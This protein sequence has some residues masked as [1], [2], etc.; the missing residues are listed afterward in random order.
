MAKGGSKQYP[1]LSGYLEMATKPVPINAGTAIQAILAVAGSGSLIAGT[2]V[3]LAGLGHMSWGVLIAECAPLFAVPLGCALG[4]VSVQKLVPKRPKPSALELEAREVNVLLKKH[5][6]ERRLHKAAPEAVTALLEELS[7]QYLRVQTTLS[8]NFWRTTDLP[9]PYVA[10]RDKAKVASDRAM[11]EAVVLL[12]PRMSEVVKP[13][14]WREVVDEVA[15]NLGFKVPDRG[16][17]FPA[18]I[19]PVRNL[20]EG[21][22]NLANEVEQAS[23]RAITELPNSSSAEASL[24]SCLTEL[25]A[26]NDAESEL[27]DSLRYRI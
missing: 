15:E 17:V 10:L 13:Q 9:Q 1:N 8:T 24:R 27:D 23:I 22:R 21:L 4:A 7:R 2:G 6:K 3:A 25:R 12:R 5:L 14:D 11:N 19:E 18:D 20:A 26:L 16:Y